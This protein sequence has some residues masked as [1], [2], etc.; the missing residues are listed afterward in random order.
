MARWRVARSGPVKNSAE[1]DTLDNDTGLRFKSV[2]SAC[3][4]FVVQERLSSVSLI[5]EAC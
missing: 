2:L 5:I 3:E 1:R 4:D